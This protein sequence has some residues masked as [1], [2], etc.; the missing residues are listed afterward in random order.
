MTGRPAWWVYIVEEQ[1]FD[2]FDGL[3]LK[4]AKGPGYSSFF[5]GDGSPKEWYVRSGK[6]HELINQAE[7]Q[8]RVALRVGLPLV[9]YVAD[10]NI[11]EF[12]ARIFKGSPRIRATVR[13]LPAQP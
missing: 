4:E 7:S 5:N 9:W 3:E 2:G 12:L 6:F 10:E 13:Y 1:E 11:A 8:S